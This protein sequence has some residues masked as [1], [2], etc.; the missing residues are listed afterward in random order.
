MTDM[1]RNVLL[2]IVV[3]TMGYALWSFFVASRYQAMCQISYW[4]ATDSQLRACDEM[5]ASLPS[6]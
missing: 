4:S 6:N 3:A 2:A 5:R 1:H